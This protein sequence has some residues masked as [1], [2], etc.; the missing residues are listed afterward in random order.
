M[1]LAHPQLLYQKPKMETALDD[2]NIQ[3]KPIILHIKYHPRGI[4]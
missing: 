3:K 2:T 4:T 1:Q